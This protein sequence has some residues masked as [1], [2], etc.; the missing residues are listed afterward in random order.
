[1]T[2]YLVFEIFL[3][4]SGQLCSVERIRYGR[5]L[6]IDTPGVRK[7]KGITGSLYSAGKC[8]PNIGNG[9]CHSSR[10]QGHV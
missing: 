8:Y 4:N 7:I 9:Q 2:R 10:I 1:V 3:V 5:S 6:Q